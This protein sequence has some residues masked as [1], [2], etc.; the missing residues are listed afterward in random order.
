MSQAITTNTTS[1]RSA[2]S[3]SAAAIVA[4]MAAPILARSAEQD[5]DADLIALCSEAENCEERI[6]EIDRDRGSD[7]PE[8]KQKEPA[9]LGSMPARRW[10]ISQR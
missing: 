8:K 7:T 6:R 10:R 5:R 4:G 2:L 9:T 1:R 3:L